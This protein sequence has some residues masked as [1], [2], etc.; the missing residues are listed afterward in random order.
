MKNGKMRKV[1]LFISISA[2]LFSTMEVALK[3]AASDFDA[4]QMTFTRFLWGGIVLLPFAVMEFRKRSIMI[5]KDDLIYFMLLG[6]INIVVSM[7]FFQFA[8]IY[9]KA[10]SVAVVFCTNPMFT[11][12]FAHFLTEEKMNKNKMIA[13]IISIVGLVFIMNPMH[14]RQPDDLLGIIFAFASSVT[15]GLYSAFGKR[16][17]KRYGGIAQTSISFILGTLVLLVFLIIMDKPI[18]I[19]IHSNNVVLIIYIS[20][21]VTG[22][23]YL[24]YFMAM[25]HSDTSFASLVFFVKPALAPIVAVLILGEVI[26]WNVIVG[27]VFILVGSYITLGTGNLIKK[28]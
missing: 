12:L 4:F 9:T 1:L 6:I 14:I 19:D 13:L 22:G 17:I 10:S 23:G 18:L 26:T 3:I 7:T 27:I 2:V 25:E 5:T 8:V 11:M 24:A 15:F 20:V 28:I 21:F 16:R